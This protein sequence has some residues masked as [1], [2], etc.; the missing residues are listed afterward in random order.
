[1]SAKH[2]SKYCR[3]DKEKKFQNQEMLDLDRFGLV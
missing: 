2:G 1:M 3:V